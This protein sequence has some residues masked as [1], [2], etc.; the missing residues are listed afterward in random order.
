MQKDPRVWKDPENFD[1]GRFLVQD[2]DSPNKLRADLLHLNPFGGGA[3]MC[4]GRLYAEREVLFF[5]AALLTVWDFRLNEGFKRPDQFYCGS[6][7]A[8]PKTPVKVRIS[9]RA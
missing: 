1:P 5:V 6:G 9:R 8:N 4:K 2:E 3:S 7:T